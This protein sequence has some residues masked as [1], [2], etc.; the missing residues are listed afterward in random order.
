MFCITGSTEEKEINR[1]KR[2]FLKDHSTE[3]AYFAR[4]EMRRKQMKEVNKRPTSM[5]KQPCAENTSR[6]HLQ[7][8]NGVV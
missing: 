5:L 2:R 6:Q 8:L 4:R 1:L 3:Q 7:A